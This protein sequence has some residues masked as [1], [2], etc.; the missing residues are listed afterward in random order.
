MKDQLELLEKSYW[1]AMETHNLERIMKL[2]YFPCIIAGKNGV[3]QINEDTFIDM[4]QAA[5][6]MPMQVLSISQV[7]SEVIGSTGVIAYLIEAVHHMDGKKILT[8]AACS[9]T[10]VLI[11]DE[12]KCLLHT[13]ADLQSDKVQEI[14]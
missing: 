7:S 6:S 11:A 12:W 5:E 3:K 10:W 2:T 14:S 9:S 8:K 1:D 4:F 13:D